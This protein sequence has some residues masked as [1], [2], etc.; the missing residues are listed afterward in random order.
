M[1]YVRLAV[2]KGKGYNLFDPRAVHP[3]ITTCTTS[4]AT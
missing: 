1:H 4:K 2:P 3:T